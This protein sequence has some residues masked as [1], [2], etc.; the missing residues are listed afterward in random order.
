MKSASHPSP[1]VIHPSSE[2]RMLEAS[3]LS[4]LSLLSLLSSE[5]S[6]SED[7]LPCL[8]Q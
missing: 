8:K 1:G 3:P 6:A 5:A 2:I 4:L 7:A